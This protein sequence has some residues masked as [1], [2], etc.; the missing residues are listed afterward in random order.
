MMVNQQYDEGLM[1]N[2]T[3]AD[4]LGKGG[5]HIQTRKWGIS[6]LTKGIALQEESKASAVFLGKT[7]PIRY[8]F[9][10]FQN[11]LGIIEKGFVPFFY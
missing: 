11:F 1:P 7:K 9:L 10:Q 5:R 2:F 3:H 6:M 4:I 8:L